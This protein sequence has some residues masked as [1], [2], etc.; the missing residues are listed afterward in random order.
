MTR[1]H[2]EVVP[3]TVTDEADIADW[4]PGTD[5]TI[6]LLR[7][8]AVCERQRTGVQ[9]R[10]LG[11]DRGRRISSTVDIGI[12]I[13]TEDGLFVPVLRDVAQSPSR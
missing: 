6:R 4:P 8:M 2:A 9:R 12:A 1:A 13:D 11:R 7:A 5:P 3:A 10:V